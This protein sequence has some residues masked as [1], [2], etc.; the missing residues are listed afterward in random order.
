[1]NQIR[2][3]KNTMLIYRFVKQVILLDVFKFVHF[4]VHW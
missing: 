2:A 3:T 1:M 4:F